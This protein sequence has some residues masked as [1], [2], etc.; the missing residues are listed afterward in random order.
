MIEEDGRACVCE[1]ARE[2]VYKWKTLKWQR[3][4]D[5]CPTQIT[6][7]IDGLKLV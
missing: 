4:S 7:L 3:W 5:L 1:R 6:S 2:R